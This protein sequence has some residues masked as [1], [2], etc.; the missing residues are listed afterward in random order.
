LNARGCLS[1]ERVKM[2][3]NIILNAE[4]LGDIKSSSDFIKLLQ[5]IQDAEEAGKMKN[6]IDSGSFATYESNFVDSLEALITNLG[7]DK[8]RISLEL[9][10]RNSLSEQNQ[11]QF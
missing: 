7:F 2:P 4:D 11:N 6:K 10:K 1:L 3:I 8:K 9:S 5:K